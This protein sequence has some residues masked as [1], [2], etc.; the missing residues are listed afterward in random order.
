M[1]RGHSGDPVELT[2][3]GAL[4]QWRA[5]VRRDPARKYDALQEAAGWEQA[6]LDALAAGL[7]SDESFATHCFTRAT[8]ILAGANLK[9]LKPAPLPLMI[10]KPRRRG[11]TA[12]LQGLP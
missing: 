2:G 5:E 7:P 1:G 6:G 4:A 10:P 11:I 8:E 9:G 12:G 3:P